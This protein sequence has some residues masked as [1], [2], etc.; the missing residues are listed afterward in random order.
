MGKPGTQSNLRE[1][2]VSLH[3]D[4]KQELDMVSSTQKLNTKLNDTHRLSL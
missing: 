2:D 1:R 3:S 4:N